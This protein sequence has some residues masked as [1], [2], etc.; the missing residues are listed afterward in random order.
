MP[1]A[2]FFCNTCHKKHPTH[3]KL[4]DTLYHFQNMNREDCPDCGGTQELHLSPDFQ[5]GCG[6]EEFKIVSA[7]LP[8][9]L[10]SWLGEEAQEVTFYPF[11]VVIERVGD[12]R[13]FCWM[14]Y[15]HVTGKEARYGQHA[16][17]VDRAQFEDLIAQAQEKIPEKV[18]EFV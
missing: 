10:D 3:Q 6:D 9:K 1:S 16:M 15:W 18:L 5:L 11:L 2:H 13:Q 7:F 4:F 17:C 14:P 12:G 8:E